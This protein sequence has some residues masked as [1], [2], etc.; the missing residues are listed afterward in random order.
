M[1]RLAASSAFLPLFAILLAFLLTARTANAASVFTAPNGCP[2]ALAAAKPFVQ[3]GPRGAPV[4]G[5]DY[6]Y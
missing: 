1:S 3:Y 6:Q 5:V 2:T 4:A